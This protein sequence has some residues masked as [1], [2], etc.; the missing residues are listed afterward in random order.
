MAKY[1]EPIYL[2]SE[3]RKKITEKVSE[4]SLN[5]RSRYI[6]FILKKDLQLCSNY[7]CLS[8]IYKN[9]LCRN[10]FLESKKLVI[11]LDD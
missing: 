5:S 2:E 10:C 6:R 4:L 3:I 9:D 11:Q 1:L 7:N 8:P